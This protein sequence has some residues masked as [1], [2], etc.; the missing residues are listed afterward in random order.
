MS[1]IGEGIRTLICARCCVA[2]TLHSFGVRGFEPRFA[3]RRVAVHT[4]PCSLVSLGTSLVYHKSGKS[5]VFGKNF[6]KKF[7]EVFNKRPR[8]RAGQLSL[9]AQL[10]G[11]YRRQLPAVAQLPARSCQLP[12]ALWAEAQLRAARSSH[13]KPARGGPGSAWAARTRESHHRPR[14]TVMVRVAQSMS[15]GASP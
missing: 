14:W 3:L 10:A 9:P 2:I 4:T 12:S 15:I 1:H 7:C 8:R 11:A 5:Q 13:A 6:F